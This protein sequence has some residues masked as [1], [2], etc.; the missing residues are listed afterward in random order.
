VAIKLTGL[1]VHGTIEDLFGLYLDRIKIQ[2]IDL[3]DFA[4][5]DDQKNNY[6]VWIFDLVF[7][8]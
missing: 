6:S 1:L 3:I 2:K 4:R 8:S 7:T 5:M